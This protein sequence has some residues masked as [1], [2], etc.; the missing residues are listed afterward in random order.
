MN[1]VG[2][3]HDIVK[4]ARMARIVG[5]KSILHRFCRRVLHPV[6][7]KPILDRADEAY[8]IQMLASTWAAKEALF[9]SLSAEEQQNCV[10]SEW[11]R[12]VNPGTRT[13]VNAEYQA[14]TGESFLV[15]VSHDGDYTSATVLRLKGAIGA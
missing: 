8:K 9:K 15:S 11:Y 12:S 3:G 4:T 10:F 14:R 7:E 6:Y 13:L 5:N 1:A 2:L